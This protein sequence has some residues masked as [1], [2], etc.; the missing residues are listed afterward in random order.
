MI[1]DNT[2]SRST[3]IIS[4]K[5]RLK[6]LDILKLKISLPVKHLTRNSI[7]RK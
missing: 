1:I 2:K 4:H 5:A 7:K 3:K 6:H